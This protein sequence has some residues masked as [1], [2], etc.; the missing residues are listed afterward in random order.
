[1]TRDNHNTRRFAG[2]AAVLAFLCL[3]SFGV[4]QLVAAFGTA[5]DT[6]EEDIQYVQ[7]RLEE[8]LS[9]L[10]STAQRV[11]GAQV[12]EE[13][14]SG[15]V[16]EGDSL[17][18]AFEILNR[19]SDPYVAVEVYRGNGD[20]VAWNGFSVPIDQQ[21]IEVPDT[22]HYAAVVDPSGRRAVEVCYPF[23]SRNGF[24]R[25]VRTL[26]ISVPVHNQFLQDYSIADQWQT[27]DIPPFS[28]VFGGHAETVDDV[29]AGVPLSREGVEFGYVTFRQESDYQSAVS[30]G[31]DFRSISLF[32]L[33]LLIVWILAWIWFIA[34]R[35]LLEARIERS[36]WGRATT[37]FFIWLVLV[38]AS[39]QIILGVEVPR[40]WFEDHQVLGALFDPTQLASSF[41]FGWMSTAGDLF[42]TSCF[43]AAVAAVLTRFALFATEVS[44]P[45][46]GLLNRMNAVIATI[47]AIA[48]VVASV[49]GT[50]H[51]IRSAVLDSTLSFF[52]QTSPVPTLVPCVV[53]TGLVMAVVA[54]TVLLGAVIVLLAAIWGRPIRGSRPIWLSAVAVTVLILGVAYA[55]GPLHGVPWWIP[56]AT[57]GL[58]A[59]AWAFYF[60]AGSSRWASPL[61]FRGILLSV[62]LVVPVVYVSMLPAHR[63]R[64]DA[65]MVSAAD[66]FA[67]GQDKRLVFAI[68]EV[69]TEAVSNEIQPVLSRAIDRQGGGT[70]TGES[71]ESADSTDAEL[72][73]YI[74][75]MVSGS[76]LASLADYTIGVTIFDTNTDSLGSYSAPVPPNEE[77]VRLVQPGKDDPLEFET[78]K[79]RY[80]AREE[81][82][83]LVS[84]LPVARQRGIY[85]YAGISPFRVESDSILAWLH[86]RA[87]P[88]LRS[89]VAETPFPRVLVPTGL[90]GED[91]EM[92]SYAEYDNGILVR[93]RGGEEGPS[94]LE[95]SV[96]EAFGGER[97]IL[98]REETLGGLPY[99][100]YYR[101]FPTEEKR[102]P[103][104]AVAVRARSQ[105][106]YDHLFN[107]LRITTAGLFLGAV[108]FLFGLIA[109]YRAGLFPAKRTTFRDKVMVR[110][111]I[112]GIATVAATAV[113]GQQVIEEQNRRGVRELLI[114]RLQ[115]V[116]SAVTANA[117][118]GTAVRDVLDQSRA[119]VV[120]SLLGLD[121]HVYRGPKLVSTS[122]PQLA[123]QLL[124]DDRL[125]P[126]VYLDLFVRR[127]RYAF[128]EQKIGSF[129]YTTGFRS[130]ADENGQPVGAVAVPTLPEQASIEADQ[131]RMIAYLFGI[132][133]ILLVGIGFAAGILANQLTR[134][135][136]RLRRG[137]LAVGAGDV[138]DP[139][140]IETR[141]EMGELAE[142]FNDMQAQ[143]E[144]SRR[145]LAQ[146]ERELAWREMAQQVAH[147]IKN[148]LTPM[149]LS[150]QHLR[151]SYPGQDDSTDRFGKSLERI[152]STLIEQIDALDRIAGDFSSFARLP[153]HKPEPVDLHEVVREAADL[154]SAEAGE[155]A[156]IS[157]SLNAERSVVDTDREE[158]RRLFINLFKNALQAVPAG[159]T[160]KIRAET[161]ETGSEIWCTV[162]DNGAGIPADVRE[163]IFQPSFSTKSSGMGLGLAIVKKA[164]EAAGGT[165]SFE[166]SVNR[167]T[168]FRIVL[169][170]MEKAP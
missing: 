13:A 7:E 74:S 62:M 19:F 9:S 50:V 96:R 129:E 24:V 25:V 95:A 169:P 22:L 115:R 103:L 35:T 113:I 114:Q 88:R 77:V 45:D 99:R 112:V 70:A 147:E 40:V 57:V 168:T 98:W 154:F 29:V 53:L 80:E 102:E 86:V 85:R 104:D 109:R 121:V 167:G 133:L 125:P 164:V 90:F 18:A 16:S 36:G 153:Q 60:T 143:L 54:T 116:Q 48:L 162:S 33:V 23:D 14:V 107:L 145:I 84:R 61:T 151:R 132:L 41:A 144:N 127:Q 42:V 166:T 123:R 161:G 105:T 32:W 126:A 138:S 89:Y 26:Q 139:I 101:R 170:L 39:R 137:L 142:T 46:S 1:M 37:L 148:P 91:D 146:Q 97:M 21:T 3:I 157:L 11:V 79:A 66:D 149:K 5:P 2:I 118:P 110:F 59:V 38:V 141:D 130:I 94:E 106:F 135:L 136:A 159:R 152:S 83:L 93:S 31:N 69:L 17:L 52:A 134:P 68:E 20:L 128:A 92:F 44:Q 30:G 120:S 124:I 4:E 15:G 150:V 27:N 158:I 63:E 8:V 100:T 122:R 34:D 155:E 51:G 55:A 117:G 81:T 131:A 72:D 71:A 43:L 56:I 82:G 28:I 119:D 49:Y 67:R 111:L 87:T 75:A 47:V 73:A 64:Q 160:P 78:L 140:P 58:L 12:V 108:L 163:R 65:L 10:E 165:I 156:T 76:L 6:S